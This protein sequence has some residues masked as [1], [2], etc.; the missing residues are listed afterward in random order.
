MATHIKEL[1]DAA[2]SNFLR[3]QQV[4]CLTMTGLGK[5]RNMIMGAKPRIL[6][7]EEAAEILEAHIISSLTPTIQ[8]CI[9]IGDHKQ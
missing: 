1:K 5:Y 4:I 7:L 3:Q 6:M 8:Q 9:L 2:Q